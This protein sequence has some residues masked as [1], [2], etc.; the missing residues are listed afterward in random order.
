MDHPRRT[1]LAHLARR[2]TDQTEN[3]ATEGLLFMLSSSAA[4]RQ[5]LV[6]LAFADLPEVERGRLELLF[7]SQVAGEDESRPDLIGRDLRGGEAL[8]IEAKFWAGLT[9]NQ[10]ATYLERLPGDGPSCLLFVAPNR[11]FETLWPEL[12]ERCS[13]AGESVAQ[14]DSMTGDR[15][16]LLRSGRVVRLVSWDRVLG[17]L[18]VAAQA[19]ADQALSEDVR[20]LKS[21]CAEEDWDAF[22]PVRSEELSQVSPHRMRQ[23]IE[24]VDALVERLQSNG[25]ATKNGLRQANTQFE[26][27]HYLKLDWCCAFVHTDLVKW[28]TMRGTPFWLRLHGAGWKGTAGAVR[29]RLAELE[30]EN[31]PRLLFKQE[32]LRDSVVVPLRIRL[33]SE[34][35]VVLDDL[36]DQIKRVCALLGRAPGA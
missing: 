20:Q 22:I 7:Q 11:R 28:S 33:N 10:P 6:G 17:A 24:L 12:L 5:A 32:D 29:Q 4:A 34:R 36:Y 30:R 25:L 35:N 1:I 14:D 9:A 31:P 26:Q 3:L 27:G 21:L 2:F 18:D 16:C 19:A 23:F 8:I 15:R 13:Q